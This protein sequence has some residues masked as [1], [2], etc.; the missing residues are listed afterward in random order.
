MNKPVLSIFADGLR[1]DSL[2]YLPFLSSLNSAPLET[3]LGYSITCHPSMYSGVYPDKHK[4]C[5]HWVHS[6]ETSPYRLFSFIP[7]ISPFTN[8]YVQAVFSHFYA[9]IFLRNNAFMGYSKILN[10]PMM[11]WNKLEANEKKYWDEDNY[12]ES[13]IKTIFEIVRKEGLRHYISG[14]YKPNLGKLEYIK[15]IEPQNYDWVYYFTGD[16]DH[17]SHK[18]TQHSKETIEYL[19]KLDNFI[20]NRYQEFE[21]IFGKDKFTFIFWSDHGH[22]PTKKRIDLYDVSKKRK[23]NLYKTFHIVDSTT[24]RFWVETNKEKEIIQEVMHSVPDANLVSEQEFRN[25]H[26]PNER[27]YYGDL[28]YYLRGGSVFNPTIHG[29]GKN[30]ISMHGYHPEAEGNRGTFVSNRKITINKVTLPD[31]F[32]STVSSLGLSKYLEGIDGINRI[33]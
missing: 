29:F 2:I 9:K 11:F 30:S 27:K 1:H 3:I 10:F 22:I 7:N 19:K 16:T 20:Q 28:F 18:Y 6:P 21:R 15:I 8:P 17:L 32:A 31:V 13:K 14:I 5:F 12:L 33:A 4:I 23:V 24:V 26:L 25:L